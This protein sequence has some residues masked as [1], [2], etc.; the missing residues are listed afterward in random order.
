VV[1]SPLFAVTGAVAA[2]AAAAS[3]QQARVESLPSTSARSAP[4]AIERSAA[5]P[6]GAIVFGRDGNLYRMQA[7]G[8]GPE[9]LLL[10]DATAAAA[11]PNGK[12][13]AFVR[14]HAIWV[15]G[16]DGSTPRRLTAVRKNDSDWEAPSAPAW[17]AHG[18]SVIFTRGNE[19]R[20][21]MAIWSV[22]RD[23]SSERLL[24]GPKDAEACYMSP[25]PSPRG[26][27]VAY[28]YF[29][30]CRH[31]SDPLIAAV[32]TTGRPATLPF[33][34]PAS[35]SE[36]YGGEGLNLGQ[37]SW[38]PDGRRL[39]YA[40]YDYAR[41]D[42]LEPGASQSG[43]YVS[44]TGGRAPRR[45]VRAGGRNDTCGGPDWAPDG[46]WIAFDRAR[47]EEH[48]GAGIWL[49]RP[50]GSGLRRLTVSGDSPAWLPP[51]AS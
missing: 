42:P 38:S 46:A 28:T 11:S 45:L 41:R 4:A 37:A 30:D 43:I 6:V 44:T 40:A 27:L 19:G 29:A 36:N 2:V 26:R 24:A 18:T 32:T 10:R 50:D 49:V 14:G 16:R 12:Q 1:R 8:K 39:A 31:G 22:G 21:T 51:L 7:N 34:F 20:I 15:M 25:A 3:G 17:S 35:S 13:I 5:A 48:A 33:D 23:G 9:R 47:G